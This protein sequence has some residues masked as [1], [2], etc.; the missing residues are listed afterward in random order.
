MAPADQDLALGGIVLSDERQPAGTAMPSLPRREAEV[1]HDF[2]RR[3]GRRDGDVVR[4]PRA[5]QARV[6][7]LERSPRG[8]LREAIARQLRAV[9]LTRRQTVGA[10]RPSRGRRTGSPAGTH[11]YLHTIDLP[12]SYFGRERTDRAVL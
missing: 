12:R 4:L 5:A 11:G 1:L 9:L 6:E 2:V 10:S 7:Y 8:L 3:Y